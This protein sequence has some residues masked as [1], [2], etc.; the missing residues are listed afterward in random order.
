[1]NAAEIA[2]FWLTFSPV[3]AEDLQSSKNCNNQLNERL[4]PSTMADYYETSSLQVPNTFMYTDISRVKEDHSF[5]Q[6]LL[7]EIKLLQSCFI[8][9]LHNHY[10][11]FE[12]AV[13]VP[14]SV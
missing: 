13:K 3:V 1:M 7:I 4:M 9:R 2:V 6:K 8:Y 14:S 12:K 11:D 5:S 10:I